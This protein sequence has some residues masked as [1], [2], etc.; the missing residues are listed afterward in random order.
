MSLLHDAMTAWLAGLTTK[1]NEK[2]IWWQDED[3]FKITVELVNLRWE[4]YIVRH[5]FKNGNLYR[6]DSYMKDNPHGLCKSYWENGN[7]M[8]E[9]NYLKGKFCGPC[10]HYLEN[11][12]LIP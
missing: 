10:K 4:K 6:E 11:G 7:L 3:G 5:Y 2:E 9:Y 8:C 1:K 12:K